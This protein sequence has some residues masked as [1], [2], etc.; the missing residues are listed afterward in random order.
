MKLHHRRLTRRLHGLSCQ[1]CL[2]HSIS[3][4]F[5]PS[6]QH[7]LCP[8]LR[9]AFVIRQRSERKSW[10]S[11]VYWLMGETD[12]KQNATKQCGKCSIAGAGRVYGAERKEVLI[13]S[14]ASGDEDCEISRKGL[15]LKNHQT[16]WRHIKEK[17]KKHQGC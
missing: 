5:F 6:F 9:Q 12:D 7:M 11:V 2:F 17:K 8:S 1:G 13:C 15:A 4:H 3:L 10:S 16:F 14:E